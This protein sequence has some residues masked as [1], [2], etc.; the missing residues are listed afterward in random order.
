MGERK[1][2]KHTI[3]AAVLAQLPDQE[4]DMEHAM[5]TWWQTGRSTGGLRLSAQGDAYFKLAEIEFFMCPVEKIP[6]GTWYSFV[7]DLSLKI[8]T[9]YYLSST[10]TEDKKGEPFVRVYDSK[11]AMMIA[12]YGSLKEYL[13]SIPSR[14]IGHSRSK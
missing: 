1:S 6:A 11:I 9:P 7:L 4:I 10:T 14:K 12:L 13:D 2:L 5:S 3:T 8:K